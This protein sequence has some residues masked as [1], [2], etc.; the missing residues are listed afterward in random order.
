MWVLAQRTPIAYFEARFV[1][2]QGA[3]QQPI[4]SFAE[5][6]TFCT[7]A[8]QHTGLCSRDNKQFVMRTNEGVLMHEHIT[9]SETRACPCGGT[10]LLFIKVSLLLLS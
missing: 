3:D 10:M 6:L 9:I 5:K 7:L 4:L 8:V 2:M 1:S